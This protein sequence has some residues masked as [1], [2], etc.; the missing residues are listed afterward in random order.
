MAMDRAMDR[1]F[2][3][4]SLLLRHNLSRHIIVGSIA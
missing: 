4:A 2:K 3:Q 1:L